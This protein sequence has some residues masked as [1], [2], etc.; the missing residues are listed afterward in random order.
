MY[1]CLY[2]FVYITVGPMQ[3][4]KL[5]VAD[6]IALQKTSE[7]HFIPE[8]TYLPIYLAIKTF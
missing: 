1:L 8:Y 4:F 7:H 5:D 6:K 3:R 2:I